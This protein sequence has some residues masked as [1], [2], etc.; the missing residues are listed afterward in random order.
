[1]AICQS[2]ANPSNTS[3]NSCS[4]GCNPPTPAAST[5]CEVCADLSAMDCVYY[6]GTITNN[7]NLGTNF[8]L[9]TFVEKAIPIL[10][11]INADTTD[12]FINDLT[13]TPQSAKGSFE[14]TTE[15]NN[16]TAG[17]NASFDVSSHF[18]TAAIT[19]DTVSSSGGEDIILPLSDIGATNID[20]L[21]TADNYLAVMDNPGTSREGMR[22]VNLQLFFSLSDDSED[23]I[24]VKVS[25]YNETGGSLG[26]IF[27]ETITT[28]STS[29]FKVSGIA[30]TPF[31]YGDY[32]Q[33]SIQSDLAQTIQ[34]ESYSYIGI[35]ELY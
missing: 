9:K 10:G 26:P 3:T 19:Y 18:A 27:Q 6:K 28:S 2:C 14:V 30:F 25:K 24:I 22:K 11:S 16:S 29:I 23:T 1:M 12:K 21:V 31:S 17:P 13:I 32:I 35:Q 8:R 15:Y 5:S 20:V 7:L 33:V 4:C 34:I